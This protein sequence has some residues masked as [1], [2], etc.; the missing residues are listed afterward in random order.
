[1]LS[2]GDKLRRRIQGVASDQSEQESSDDEDIEGLNLEGSIARIKQRAFDEL[3][4][5]GDDE[6][7][8]SD[9]KK[10]GNGVFEMKFM[11]DAIARQAV[12][13]NKEVD[14]FTREM[15]GIVNESDEEATNITQEGSSNGVIAIRTGGRVVY[16]PG[17]SV[18]EYGFIILHR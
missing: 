1:M 2:R 5:L 14:D 7:A 3:A 12:T 8:E 4:G 13:V 11:K 17:A 18:S 16:Q 9:G 6:I 15:G 10:K